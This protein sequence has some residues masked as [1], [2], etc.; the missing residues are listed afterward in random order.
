MIENLTT[1]VGAAVMLLAGLL[2]VVAW[3]RS[4]SPAIQQHVDA[5]TKVLDNKTTT[6]LE[7]LR[8]CESLMAYFEHSRN[9]EG[10]DALQEVVAQV[11]RQGPKL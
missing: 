6:R 5:L 7:A 2:A 10:A 8:D 9:T 4:K 3:A 1:I 11:F